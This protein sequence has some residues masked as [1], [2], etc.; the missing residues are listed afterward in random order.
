MS[1]SA[2]RPFGAHT[3]R[4][5]NDAPTLSPNAPGHTSVVAIVPERRPANHAPNNDPPPRST[6]SAYDTGTAGSVAAA[7]LIRP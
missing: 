1:P 2:R 4:T 7:A 6:T 5:P 3:N